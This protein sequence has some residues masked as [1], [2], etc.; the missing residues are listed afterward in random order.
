MQSILI[1]KCLLQC[2]AGFETL[3]VDQRRRIHFLDASQSVQTKLYV[4]ARLNF[5]RNSLPLYRDTDNGAV[6]CSLVMPHNS[7]FT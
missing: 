5:L 1:W 3:A 2:F 6:S 7:L 4:V